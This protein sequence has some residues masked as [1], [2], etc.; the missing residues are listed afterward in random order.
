MQFTRGD[1]YKFKFQR[2]DADGVVITAQ[3]SV[4]Y[5]TVKYN[6][7]T[8]TPA[9]QKKFPASDF[10]YSAIDETY[11]VTIQPEETEL[12]DIGDYI[13]DIEVTTGSYVQTIAKGKLSLLSESTWSVNKE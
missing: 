6:K 5:F 3:P 10:F 8:K 12:L 13:Y 2:K 9:L 11:H 4:I 7:D 1:T